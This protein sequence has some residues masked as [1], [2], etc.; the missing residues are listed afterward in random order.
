MASA[1]SSSERFNS[2]IPI[3]RRIFQGSKQGTLHGKLRG[4]LQSV[5]T[6]GFIIGFIA[7]GNTEAG[8][9][10]LAVARVVRN[11]VNQGR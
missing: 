2:D 3:V 11:S 1:S 8:A 9:L 10:G 4:I 6:P 7:H 5:Q